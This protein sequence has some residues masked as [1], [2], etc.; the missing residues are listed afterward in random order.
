MEDL[1]I[2]QDIVWEIDAVEIFRQ[3]KYLQ[4]DR[5]DF[6][7]K[8]RKI[9]F[10]LLREGFKRTVRKINSSRWHQ[11]HSDQFLTFI[12]VKKDSVSYLNISIQSQC[13][14][15]KCVIRNSFFKLKAET[16]VEAIIREC[17]TLFERDGAYFNQFD[18]F[19]IPETL[20]N[21]EFKKLNT[22][23][24]KPTTKNS[25]EGVFI[26]GLGGYAFTY[27]LPEFR[28]CRRIACVDYKAER[29]EDFKKEFGFEVALYHPFQAE[30]L[31]R[32]IE[33]PIVIIATYHSDHATIAHWAFRINSEARIFIEKPPCVNL[34]DLNLLS[35]IYQNQGSIE[36]G[37]NR[38]YIPV[39]K[40]IKEIVKGKILII[41]ISVKEVLI[42]ENHW[43]YWGY[44]GSRITGNLIH[45]IDL[46]N[47]WIDSEVS[48]IT[49]N[50][51]RLCSE[52]INISLAYQN[53]SIVNLTVSDK[54]NS[55]RG[56]QELIEIRYD[57]ETILIQDYL[58]YLHV[59]SSG[60]KETRLFVMRDKGHTRMY[61][62][63]RNNLKTGT[64]NYSL[65]DL[66][67]TSVITIRASQML[68]E[69]Q[70]FSTFA[71]A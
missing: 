68:L 44:Q 38:R 35:G 63:F 29:A 42:E 19:K 45:W 11:S 20:N 52:D 46:V 16:D 66:E 2:F 69:S 14:V 15:G 55:L 28:S 59:K 22:T 64:F 7:N 58:K 54:G 43:Y 56:V 17:T 27:I 40:K 65:K 33:K 21:F 53:G 67:R 50:T 61:R 48:S 41:T 9:F 13:E 30:E 12:T 24:Y 57:N 51:S 4:R 32:T 62:E 18:D 10:F 8:F 36:I 3:K 25:K 5:P 6:D 49:M 34:K 31:L 39:N 23:Y 1:V 71:E 60:R 47:Y 70:K 26:F 37:F